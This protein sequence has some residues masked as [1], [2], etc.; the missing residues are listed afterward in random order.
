MNTD[1]TGK[2][3]LRE[4]VGN[5]RKVL[6]FVRSMDKNYFRIVCVTHVLDIGVP[7]VELL[8]SAYILDAIGA[9]RSFREMMTV[10]FWFAGSICIICIP[11]W[12]RHAC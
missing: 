5:I 3:P 12:F 8:L 2:L 4:H 7:Y 6:K 10:V 9:H 11:A 1:L